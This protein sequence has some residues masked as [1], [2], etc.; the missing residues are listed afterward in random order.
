MCDRSGVL[1]GGK[2]RTTAAGSDGDAKGSGAVAAAAEARGPGAEG[3]GEGA[4]AAAAVA[5]FAASTLGPL[6]RNGDLIPARFLSRDRRTRY[7]GL[8]R[9]Q[10]ARWR[11]ER[12]RLRELAWGENEFGFSF[13]CGEKSKEVFFFP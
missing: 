9:F 3:S 6:R 13:A 1:G 5:A 7:I 4:G 8:G 12:E 11:A 2:G 10:R